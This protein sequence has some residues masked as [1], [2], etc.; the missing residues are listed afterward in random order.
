MLRGSAFEIQKNYIPKST[1]K[2]AD[3]SDE[4]K[5]SPKIPRTK[6][7]VLDDQEINTNKTVVQPQPIVQ[8]P[9]ADPRIAIYMAKL[10]PLIPLA[11]N[12]ADLNTNKSIFRVIN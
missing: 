9:P 1:E 12:V 2:I 3:D 10:E 5:S 8:Q 6:S 11:Q 4:E 7:S